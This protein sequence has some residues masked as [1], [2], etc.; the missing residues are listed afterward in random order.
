MKFIAISDTHGKHRGL[1]LPKGD[2]IIHAGDF[3]H[4]GSESDLHDFLD[5]YKNLDVELKILIGGNHDASV[6]N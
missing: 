4:Y 2:A 3:C 5:W 6:L 1:K